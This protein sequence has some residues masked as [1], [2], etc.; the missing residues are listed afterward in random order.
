MSALH[1]RCWVAAR[2]EGVR[3]NGTCCRGQTRSKVP[4]AGGSGRI[5][6]GVESLS[7]VEVSVTTGIDVLR[8]NVSTAL[9]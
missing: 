9:E 7:A 6:R 4:R 3:V 2:N 1:R 8:I 5:L